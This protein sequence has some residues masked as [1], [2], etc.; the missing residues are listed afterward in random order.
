MV[1]EDLMMR[2]QEKEN[3]LKEFQRIIEVGG[4]FFFRGEHLPSPFFLSCRFFWY[5]L[6]GWFRNPKANQMVGWC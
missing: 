3:E 5:G 4:S 1:P 6:D 2:L